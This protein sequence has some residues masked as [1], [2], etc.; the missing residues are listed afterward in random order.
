[1]NLKDKRKIQERNDTI[2]SFLL[3]KSQP[4]DITSIEEVERVELTDQERKEEGE[5]ESETWTMNLTNKSI[6]RKERKFPLK[7]KLLKKSNLKNL[8]ELL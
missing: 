8:K 5:E 2:K 4:L 1:M 7:G 3:K 6:L